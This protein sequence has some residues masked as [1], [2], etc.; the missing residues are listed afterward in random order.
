MDFEYEKLGIQK[1]DTVI[2]LSASFDL[3]SKMRNNRKENDGIINDI[4]EKD[5]DYMRKV[6]DNALFVADYLNFSIIN[7]D[8]GDDMRSI[9]DIHNDICE[10]M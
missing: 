7:C 2:F 8:D 4:H 5:L 1:P 3:V 9:E 6:Y 10:L